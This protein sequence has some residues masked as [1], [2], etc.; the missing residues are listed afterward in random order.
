MPRLI[1]H[2]LTDQVYDG[3][4]NP[5]R[6]QLILEQDRSWYDSRGR[7]R[8]VEEM[9]E[10][11]LHNLLRW[12]QQRRV[13][14]RR[15]AAE[16]LGDETL[17]QRT[18]VAEWIETCPLVVRLREEIAERDLRDGEDDGDRP[19]GLS[20]PELHAMVEQVMAE[21]GPADPAIA[22]IADSDEVAVAP[23][24][25]LPRIQFDSR[26]MLRDNGPTMEEL[27]HRMGQRVDARWCYL[28]QCEEEL[29]PHGNSMCRHCA[30]GTPPIHQQLNVEAG[31]TI[32]VYDRGR[33]AGYFQVGRL[34]VRHD[35]YDGGVTLTL[36]L[37][38]VGP[39]S[40]RRRETFD[41]SR[42]TPA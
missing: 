19:R 27:S 22:H 8:A 30:M 4:E 34:E 28:H 26:A 32:Q 37:R 11:Y 40:P 21:E 17:V 14:I 5:T 7:H 31:Q 12:L 13:D 29:T 9:D 42:E 10:E 18:R 20:G 35:R 36:E 25:P 38:E 39:S 41:F 6:L 23:R 24:R 1:D 16:Y 33:L 3:A 15:M 2:G